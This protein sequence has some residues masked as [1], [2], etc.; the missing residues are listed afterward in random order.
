MLFIPNGMLLNQCIC[1]GVERPFC[2]VVKENMSKLCNIG[3]SGVASDH[4]EMDDVYE[5]EDYDL[6]TEREM[7][8]PDTV[9][10]YSGSAGLLPHMAV[11][12]IVLTLTL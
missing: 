4:V 7:L 1:D 9:V 11:L 5:D 8:D 12:L 6:K 2:E 10:S 3:D